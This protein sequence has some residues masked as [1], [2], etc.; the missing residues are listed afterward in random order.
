MFNKFSLFYFC[1]V[2]H[3]PDWYCTLRCWPQGA[4]PR[5]LDYPALTQ[6][7]LRWPAHWEIVVPLGSEGLLHLKRISIFDMR[8][9][10]AS[11]PLASSFTI[12]V[13][14]LLEGECVTLC[15]TSGNKQHN[16]SR[17]LMIFEDVSTFFLQYFI[18]GRT[19]QNKRLNWKLPVKKRRVIHHLGDKK[20]VCSDLPQ[21]KHINE[22]SAERTAY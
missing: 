4:V 15:A 3:R 17:S 19:K 5:P 12:V 11:D 9:P 21:D 8:Y 13:V 22:L 7:S 6:L 2:A 10:D 14:L 16:K 1:R 20:R 18:F